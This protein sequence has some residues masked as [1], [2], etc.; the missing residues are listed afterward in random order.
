MLLLFQPIIIFIYIYTYKF[1][2]IHLFVYKGSKARKRKLM[3]TGVMIDNSNNSNNENTALRAHRSIIFTDTKCQYVSVQSLF[4]E[5]KS[6][7][8]EG[9]EK[10]LKQHTF[11]G[12]IDYTYCSI[13]FGTRLL[14][15]DHS[16]LLRHLFYQLVIRRFSE[17]PRIILGKPLSIKDYVLAALNSPEGQ[18]SIENG[19][20]EDIVDNVL[21]ILTENSEMLE[22]YFKIGVNEFGMLCTLPE[23]LAG[24][25]PTPEGLPMFLL[26]LATE[27]N[28]EDEI[29]CFRS[30]ATEIGFL[31]AALP[32]EYNPD[33]IED[34]SSEEATVEISKSFPGAIGNDL[35]ASILMPA[36]RTYLI[37]PKQ[38]AEDG[39]TVVQL[40]ALE[41]LYKIFERC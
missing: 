28:W 5:L 1:K 26:R 15:L 6:H 11:V 25:T 13:Q 31:Y 23:L 41:Q 9:L 12:L 14:L 24:H 33:V 3:A 40:A 29:Q 37:A 32:I 38:C 8:H 21:K 18:W 7:R 36:I 22:E 4:T 39:N 27:V 16:T 35:F 19:S 34:S 20:K 2:Y 30:I 17:M 10:I